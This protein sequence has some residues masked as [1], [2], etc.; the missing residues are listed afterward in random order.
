MF[1]QKKAGR[2]GKLQEVSG[3]RYRLPVL[4]HLLQLWFSCRGAIARGTQNG[5]HHR[6]KNSVESLA[7]A[8]GF[9]GFIGGSLTS[10]SAQAAHPNRNS[11]ASA[12]S[13]QVRIEDS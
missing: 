3:T 11:S 9:A 5:G 10:L 8:V 6:M 12:Q 2:D 4:R 13:S 1:N 7:L